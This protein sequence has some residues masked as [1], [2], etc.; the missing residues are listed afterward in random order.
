MEEEKNEETGYY[1][2]RFADEALR[3]ELGDDGW[4]IVF[5]YDTGRG[6]KVEFPGMLIDDQWLDEDLGKFVGPLKNPD[7]EK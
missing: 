7:M 1:W 3:K 6:I 4:V 2:F 5:A